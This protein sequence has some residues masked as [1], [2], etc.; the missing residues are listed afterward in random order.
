[1]KHIMKNLIQIVL[2]F[3]LIG[4]SFP[5]FSQSHENSDEIEHSIPGKLD[6]PQVLHE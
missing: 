2:I 5:S 1:M 4:V 6:T 3:S